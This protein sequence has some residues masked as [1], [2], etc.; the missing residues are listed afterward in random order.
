[1]VAELRRAG[2]TVTAARR[3][4]L[5]ALDGYA[6]PASA[7]EL[8]VHLRADGYRMG[9]TTVY[10]TLHALTDAGLVHVFHVDG[11]DR[12]RHCRYG[13]HHHLICQ[14]CRTVIERPTG[15]L[16]ALLENIRM[17]TDFV[18]DPYR[19]DL[20]GTCGRCNRAHGS[21]KPPRTR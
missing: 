8:L 1:M 15:E 21:T 18:P 6:R 19:A 20:V 13:P 4:V 12:Y 10:R 2:V 9:L 17:D 5:V 7:G 16:D 14:R 11:E 3:A